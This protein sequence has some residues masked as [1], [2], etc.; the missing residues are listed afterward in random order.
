M[1]LFV[2]VV[3]IGVVEGYVG[4]IVVVIVVFGFFWCW[5]DVENIV[6]FVCVVWFVCVFFCIVLCYLCFEQ[7]YVVVFGGQEV[8]VEVVVVVEQCGDWFV[9]GQ[10]V[11]CLLV[12]FYVVC[13][14]GFED[15]C[16]VVFV[17]YFVGNDVVVFQD[18]LVGLC[19]FCNVQ[20][21]YVGYDVVNG[22]YFVFFYVLLKMIFGLLVNYMKSCMEQ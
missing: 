2:V 7:M 3:V 14:G 21:E 9:G 20:Q 4:V 5:I 15:Q 10:G 8:S 1:Q 18:D 12:D 19:K 16:I 13:V 11:D 22:V 17:Y 6:Q